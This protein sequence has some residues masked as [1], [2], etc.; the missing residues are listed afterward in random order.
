[1]L[2]RCVATSV[3][4]TT[5]LIP[6]V[7][8]HAQ[9]WRT[10][11]GNVYPDEA[12][13][14]R[15]LGGVL[16]ADEDHLIL[17]LKD[18]AAGNDGG[19]LVFMHEV[20]G[21]WSQV[22][23]YGGPSN[24]AYFL[25]ASIALD[26]D[27]AVVSR[28]SAF[29]D[30]EVFFYRYIA[31]LETWSFGGFVQAPP[32]ASASFGAS[33]AVNGLMIAVGDPGAN[34]VW[35]Y[36]DTGA[37]ALHIQELASP[38]P[39]PVA[40]GSALDFSD[41]LL[42]VGDP[43]DDVGRVDLFEWDGGG[44]LQHLDEI[45]PGWIPVDTGDEYGAVVS[46][47]GDILA[48][49]APKAGSVQGGMVVLCN[50][51]SNFSPTSYIPSYTSNFG[52][53]SSLDT[54]DDAVIVGAT[55]V[56]PTYSGFAGVYRWDGN[57][58]T[59]GEYLTL[60]TVEQG[61]Q[62][63][64][65]VALTDSNAIV[66]APYEYY[67][68][69]GSPVY[70]GSIGLFSQDCDGDGIPNHVEIAAGT[71]AD[72]N[73]NGLPDDC[74]PGDYVVVPR[75]YPTVQ[76]AVDGAPGET[77]LVAA[78]SYDEA[79]LI[80]GVDTDIRALDPSSP[81]IFNRFDFGAPA[82]EVISAL[83]RLENIAFESNFVSLQTSNGARLDLHDC[84]FRLS[85]TGINAVN[86]PDVS[87]E[88]CLF[89]GN[90]ST[91]GGG[92]AITGSDSF[93]RLTDCQ[94]IGNGG[95]SSPAV[96]THQGGAITMSGNLGSGIDATGCLFENNSAEVDH[97]GIVGNPNANAYGGAIYAS[98][99][100]QDSRFE[101]CEF[102]GNLAFASLIEGSPGDVG[103]NNARGGALFIANFE[104]LLVFVE[105]V[106]E[107]NEVR[108]LDA[109]GYVGTMQPCM[110]VDGS[111]GSSFT[112][113]N[114]TVHDQRVRRISRQ[115]EVSRPFDMFE[116]IVLEQVEETSITYNTFS[117]L[118][119]GAIHWMT[120]WYDG[121]FIGAVC[122]FTDCARIVVVN[123]FDASFNVSNFV[124]TQ[125]EMNG[126]IT[127]C[128]FD[129]VGPL[130][131]EL[132]GSSAFKGA[133]GSMVINCTFH[134]CYTDFVVGGG[135]I[136]S[137]TLVTATT[138]CGNEASA[139][140]AD[141]RW[142][143]NGG[144]TVEGGANGAMSCGGPVERAVPSSYATIDEAVMDA[145]NGDSIILATGTYN[146]TVD[147]RG[148]GEIVLRGAEG[149]DAI[150]SPPEGSPGI[151]INGGQVSVLDLT[152]ADATIGID[153][154]RGEISLDNLL[155]EDCVSDCG[156]AIRL[157]NGQENV[158]NDGASCL[159]T[160]ST[161]QNNVS[162]WNGGGICI[163]EEASLGID[164]CQLGSNT[165]ENDGGGI[166]AA[167]GAASLQMLDCTLVF[168]AAMN[169]G[170]GI[171]CRD[172]GVVD[173]TTSQFQSNSA[174]RFG[175]GIAADAAELEG[176]TFIA[177]DA[178]VVGGGMRS[179]GTSILVDCQ[180]QSNTAPVSGGLAATAIET[181]VD[182]FISCGNTGGDHYGNILTLDGAL[183]FCSDDCNSN[184]IPD[185][186]EIDSGALEDC[187]GNLVPDICED[188]SDV[189]GNGIPDACDPAAGRTV[190]LAG[191][192]SVD[193]LPAD[194]VDVLAR[195]LFRNGDRTHDALVLSPSGDGELLVLAPDSAGNYLLESILDGPSFERCCTG[196]AYTVCLNNGPA[197]G[198]S[199]AFARGDF[200]ISHSEGNTG[201]FDEDFEMYYGCDVPVGQGLPE[202]ITD[203]A[204]APESD[205]AVSI[206]YVEEE[207]GGGGLAK[208][209]V[210]I[211]GQV[212]VSKG[213]SDPKEIPVSGRHGSGQ[214][215]TGPYPGVDS[216]DVFA[217]SINGITTGDFN[218]DGNDDL[219][220][221]HPDEMQISIRNFTGLAD[222]VD[223]ETGE[224]I[225]SGATW[226]APTFFNLPSAPIAVIAGQF[227]E[228]PGP[229]DDGLDDLFVLRER[230]TGIY[231]AIYA[232][233]GPNTLSLYDVQYI[234]PV[235]IAELG[236]A[237][238][239]I[240]EDEVVLVA[241]EMT[242]TG[243]AVL[244]A[245]W[246]EAEDESVPYTAHT[247]ETGTPLGISSTPA[248][249]GASPRQVIAVL[250][251][252]VGESAV[253][254][255]EIGERPRIEPPSNDECDRPMDVFDG[256]NAIQHL[257]GD[258]Q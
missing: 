258:G 38:A 118:P 239:G 235:D 51:D 12:Y 95:N 10:E 151:R 137:P 55:G 225:P 192:G 92:A 115:G 80:D 9:L 61:A 35:V 244:W 203:Y 101:D 41:S 16:A 209:A 155:I 127:S 142:S 139:F 165:A 246:Q 152:I 216:V 75:D 182:G 120:S 49:G 168:N 42:V 109:G 215:G 160:N 40:F 200:L 166:H 111:S 190:L 31:V 69:G 88:G 145:R 114:S 66:G 231:G 198:T 20:A 58:W 138:I 233:T 86:S 59:V 241:G 213:K 249:F 201:L 108:A 144:N 220:L 99:L 96:A 222:Y 202:A 94:F 170:G 91:G 229:E 70:T 107:E 90:T 102:R 83:L 251:E 73:E 121:T 52:L 197:G 43:L 188:L 27:L 57:F 24:D 54:F 247:L 105:C 93:L 78:G 97:Y 176:C 5:I 157:G 243:M 60:E 253:H 126:D 21:V 98:N 124:G 56:D 104:G 84:S 150:I 208:V 164:S 172:V 85:A 224:L 178:G 214:G 82:M 11:T 110:Y 141:D 129:R 185:Q 53:P 26:A 30:D 183:L 22:S 255:V 117:D 148:F 8:L 135:T 149:A 123:A 81:P 45:E 248:R 17:S 39:S 76:A 154:D 13:L 204:V 167:D 29:G 228:L 1:M 223:P 44:L 125:L 4:L 46:I 205:A 221:I 63:G 250:L 6:C 122:S 147:L 106:F 116:A 65:A 34:R 112:L 171:R 194:A 217:E 146:E 18:H 71:A 179:V 181:Y 37:E 177:N 67:E 206:M 3:V 193:A 87:A 184:G 77:I 169:D 23:S 74:E 173:L 14:D 131:S 254:F 242:S 47:D 162:T 196:G 158:A 32:G 48:I 232:S 130:E 240:S 79:V 211:T 191:L 226:S 64:A 218:G 62:F 89:E 189:D 50:G 187:N 161:I 2:H 175:G 199:L 7:D 153:A 230:T 159:M 140:V 257:R 207:D 25:G 100:P 134:Q 256:A 174:G 180:F 33:L 234:F 68:D 36:K 19:W 237:V 227:V 210:P 133:E 128:S 236:K 252:K 28:T 15:S 72:Y 113:T 156:G 132:S 245:L 119:N 212:L 219:V 238:T 103:N 186:D 195:P 143:N 163:Q 136:A